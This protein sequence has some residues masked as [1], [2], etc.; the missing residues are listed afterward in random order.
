MFT[1]FIRGIL[2]Y[3]FMLLILRGMGKRQQAQFQPYEFAMALLMADL[4]A[5]PMSDVS[6]PLLHG[7]LPVVALFILHGLIT[8]LSMRNDKFRAILSGKPS[9]IV[10]RGKI[11]RDELNR[12]CL[13]LSDVL[14]GMREGGILDPAEL[15][16][17]IVEADGSISAFPHVAKRPVT[18]EDLELNPGFEGMPLLLIQDGRVQQNNLAMIPNDENWLKELLSH[19]RLEPEDVLIASLNTQGRMHVQDMSGTILSIQALK[20]E[21]VKW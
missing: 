15:G 14:E 1:I 10:S 8:V 20:Q 5:M 19:Y 6:T 21:E 3:L 11:D 4:L 2:L 7:V 9:L 18:V 17:A 12:L 13:S 16:T